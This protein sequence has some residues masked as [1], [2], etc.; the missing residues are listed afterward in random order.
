MICTTVLHPLRTR[1]AKVLI[2]VAEGPIT[3]F[4]VSHID[5]ISHYTKFVKT[6]WRPT[7]TVLDELSNI[8]AAS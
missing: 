6:I 1:A 4:L 2:T 7:I 3:P 8:G 5:I